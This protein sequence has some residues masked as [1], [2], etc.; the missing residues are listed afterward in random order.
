MRSSSLMY[1]SA[2]T[3]CILIRRS[4]TECQQGELGG[5]GGK[6]GRGGKGGDKAEARRDRGRA[7]GAQESRAG[8][9]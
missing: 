5:G 9:F 1:I 6:R 8:T 4:V 2:A 3:P 7:K